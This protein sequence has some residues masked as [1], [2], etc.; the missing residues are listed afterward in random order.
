MPARQ[1]IEFLRA[2][3]RIARGAVV[4]AAVA[5]SVGVLLSALAVL[6]LLPLMAAIGL[7]AAP[8]AGDSRIVRALL[9]AF[10]AQ[11][12]LPVALTVFLTVAVLNAAAARWQS[13]TLL[14]VGQ[15]VM[16]HQWRT[17][18]E[19]LCRVNWIVYSRYRSA[20]LL[21]TLVRQIDRIGYAA[22]YLLTL[23][24]S[25]FT[26][27]VYVALA[28]TIS[29]SITALIVGAGAALMLLLTRVRRRVARISD[30]ITRANQHMYG[31]LTE[32]LA[33]MK[34]IRAYGAEARHTEE[35]CGAAAALNRAYVQR[36]LAEG[37]ARIFFDAGAAVIL[38]VVV[39][40][41][42]RAAGLEPAALV[43]IVLLFVRLTPQ[44]SSLHVY[45]QGFFAEVGAW[46][47]V[48]D[49][50]R[51]CDAAAEPVAAADGVVTFERE[52]RLDDVSFSYGEAPMIERV[53]MAIPSGKTVAIVGPS[54]AGKSTL[55]DLVLG[56]LTP[57]H[58]RILVD[59]TPLDAHAI[60]AWRA[61]VGY[62]PQDTFLF[63]DTIRRN[64]LWAAPAA[65]DADL[66]RA[67]EAAAA[68]FVRRLPKGLDTIVGD[69]GVLLSG[70]E[71]QR[72]ALA[73]ALLRQPRLLVLDEATSA[74][75][76]ENEQL[77][78]HAVEGLHGRVSVLVIAHRLSTV[79]SADAIYVL[80]QG[81]IAE[82]GVWE[83]L[84]SRP[85]GRLRAL[86]LAQGLSTDR[87][88]LPRVANS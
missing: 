17:L 15:D 57:S 62:V 6:A 64:L 74:L 35:L 3:I 22:R 44:L 40:A 2:V 67:L 12:S 54:G 9:G 39:Y 79:R 68:D 28:A 78:Q 69:R 14:V 7:T 5:M 11:P 51:A 75:D 53:S 66:T 47:D 32:S 8:V 81:R 41:G 1:T 4:R 43:L 58:G 30:E 48:R 84:V 76:S 85:G 82:S 87:P 24:F 49:L 23:L 77:I 21:D 38:C 10:G 65:T 42:V 50:E 33:S 86:A 26:A 88:R 19:R 46:R 63:H 36:A 55:A 45:Y 37:T 31:V 71:R 83:D 80:D 18:F 70:G 61:H 20:D 73:R 60:A 13:R 27:M 34:T 56:L 16:L 29:A 52:L 25:A 72:L 59:D